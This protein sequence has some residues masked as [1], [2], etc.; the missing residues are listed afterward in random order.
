MR[1]IPGTSLVPAM[2]FF[3]PLAALALP[4]PAGSGMEIG[5]MDEPGGLP[6]G[7]E[8]SGI[9]HHPDRNSV[10]LVDDSGLL[11]EMDASGGNAVIWDLGGDLEAITR[12]DD[13]ESI[14]YL[15]VENP[16]AVLEFDL[17]TG[18]ATGEEW[19][20][21]PWLDGPNNRGLEAL[22]YV[23]GLFYAG[24]QDSGQ[25]FVFNLLPG[26]VVQHLSTTP[27]PG[28]RNDISGLHFDFCSGTLYA[29][30]DSHDVLIEMTENGN[31]LRLFSL[32]G[33]SQEGVALI[34]G[35][36]TAETSI[37]IAQD[38]GEVWRYEGYPIEPCEETDAVAPASLFHLSAWPNPFNPKVSISFSLPSQEEASLQVF[39][40]SG[41]WITTLLAGFIEA[42][43]HRIQWEGRNEA[44][45]A[46]PSGVYLIRL[47]AGAATET[48]RLVLIR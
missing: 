30:Y 6:D 28:N 15:G 11:C 24:L 19:D 20:L 8:P 12:A 40:S 33:D 9:V 45:H 31:F 16:D 7:F 3:L 48:S 27:S 29:V 43:Q 44:G 18:Q 22:T 13:S 21:T 5:W 35:S 32:P 36:S 17:N 23:N 47:R 41:R 46:L 34:G 4:W 10:I 1:M 42:G 37:F 14:V 2:L 38:A 39:D 26:G 25:I